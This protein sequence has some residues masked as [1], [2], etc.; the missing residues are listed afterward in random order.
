MNK[1]EEKNRKI[2]INDVFEAG[3]SAGKYESYLEIIK[4]Y[5]HYNDSACGCCSSAILREV[6]SDIVVANETEKKQ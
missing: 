6:L 4:E 2:S 3:Y 5:G 1:K